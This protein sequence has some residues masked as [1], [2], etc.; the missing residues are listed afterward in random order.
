[1]ILAVFYTFKNIALYAQES[2]MR[3]NVKCIFCLE[4]TFL[5]THKFEIFIKQFLKKVANVD[6][7]ICCNFIAVTFSQISFQFQTNST[8]A[9]LFHHVLYRGWRRLSMWKKVKENS[10]SGQDVAFFCQKVCLV[11]R[12]A[13]TKS[14]FSKKSG[15]VTKIAFNFEHETAR[16]LLL[17]FNCFSKSSSLLIMQK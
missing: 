12:S 7:K 14:K 3:K 8:I 5:Q 16:L 10:F 1:M 15:I 9:H 6:E 17:K 2:K 13:P 11:S 4:L